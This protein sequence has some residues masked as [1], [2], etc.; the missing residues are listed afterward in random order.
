MKRFG[1]VLLVL[2]T[3]VP[4]W[5]A[6]KVSVE[7]L[8]DTLTSMQQAK[9]S[10]EEVAAALKQLELSEEMTRSTMNSFV[11]L[12]PG[13][14]STEQVYVL[15]AQSA[16]LAPP[17]S[18]LPTTAAPDATGQ[19]ALLDKTADYVSKT[20]TQH[21]TLTAAKTTARF[22][23]N[24]E[25]AAPSSGMHG[26]A[27]DVSVGSAFVSAFQFIHFINSTESRVASQ[28]GA[29]QL[30]SEKDKT[31]WGANKMIALQ[32]PDP[33]LGN[34][35]KE[36]QD[37]STIK[38]LR[39]ELVNGKATA[40]YSFEV[41]KKKAHFPVEVCCFPNVEQAG[42]VRFSGTMGTPQMGAPEAPG[43]GKG[44]LQTSTDWHPYKANVPYHGEL[45]I[46]PDTGIVVRMITIADLK[47]TEV[48]HQQDTRI[49]YA[50]VTIDGTL[51]VLPVK[52]VIASEVVPNGDSGSAGKYS[53]RRTFFTSEYKDFQSGRPH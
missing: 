8:R 14:L 25:A 52:T 45:F 46:D 9:K 7:Q 1:S 15:E 30:P 6:K 29:E 49:D 43:T 37:A 38:W 12:V 23:D 11:P 48:V 24:V 22:Q 17:A 20:Y 35:F 31:P 2:L 53:V 32:Q 19:K 18:D 47:P 16:T 41:P 27:R 26:S 33:N 4:G 21:P 36:V 44:N 34:V 51:L 3:A 5:S 39:W 13:R 28:H 42:T 10:D 50:P 40:V